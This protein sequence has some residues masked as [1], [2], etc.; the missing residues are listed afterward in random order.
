M[1]LSWKPNR[2]N[3]IPIYLQI[4]EYIKEK[5]KYGEWPVGT[6]LPSQRKLAQMIGVNRSTVVQ[7]YEELMSEGLI[8]GVE[9]KET[10]VINTTWNIFAKDAKITDWNYYVKNSLFEPNKVFIQKINKAEFNPNIIRLGTGELSPH[11]LPVTQMKEIISSLQIAPNHLRYEEPKGSIQLRM[12]LSDHIQE[13]GIK[14]SPSNIL[15]VSG[16]LQ[17][18]QLI[19]NGL[20]RPQSKILVESPSYLFSLNLFQSLQMTLIDVPLDKMT[21][22]MSLIK[23]MKEQHNASMLYTIP[24]FHNPTSFS[25]SEEQRKQIVSLCQSIQLP[26]IEDDVYRELWFDEPPPRALKSFDYAGNILYVGSASKIISPGLRIGW[27]VGPDYVIDRLAD[28]KMQTDYGTSSISQAI[29][30]QWLEQKHWYIDH[31]HNVRDEL[32]KRRDFMVG[33]LEVYFSDLAT[34]TKPTGSFYIWLRLKQPF[35]PTLLF[36]T[37][38]E[39]NILIHPGAIYQEKGG[40]HLRLSYSY[41]SHENMEFALRELAT[42]IREKT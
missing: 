16:G 6:V 24:T 13:F 34:W 14:A 11:L 39:K 17:A 15:I 26:L 27:I 19:A 2:K 31:V 18:F 32:R 33:C 20:L 23:K 1:E 35:S 5:I 25:Y 7:A 10:K 8:E 22:Q 36:E 37:L 41:E 28:L 29:L 12:A 9:G 40:I 42:I 38:L 4:K 30:C 21:K 3:K